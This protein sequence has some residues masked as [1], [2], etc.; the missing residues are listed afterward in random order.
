MQ[1][2]SGLNVAEAQAAGQPSQPRPLPAQALDHA[3]GYLLALGV[4]QALRRRARE[5]GSWHVQVSLAR[6][7]RWLRSL[8]RLGAAGFGAP[9]PAFADVADLLEESDSPFGR[10]TTVRHAGRLS[11]TPPRWA[12]PPVPLGQDAP[13]WVA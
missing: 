1:T 3:A 2:A 6:T 9:D 11:A 5:G 12:L 13:R 7:G 4:M 8:P 10:L